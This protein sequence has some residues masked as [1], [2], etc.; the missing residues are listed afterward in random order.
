MIRPTIY[1]GYP[2]RNSDRKQKHQYRA[3]NPVLYQRE[4][5]NL[6]VSEDL[7]SSSYFTFANRRIHHQD[8]PYGNRDIRG[9]DLKLVDEPLGPGD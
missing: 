6:L 7:P 3:D 9:A 5:K 2:E 8:Q 1:S 4:Q